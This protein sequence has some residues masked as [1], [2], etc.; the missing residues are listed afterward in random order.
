M[1][2]D[3][4]LEQVRRLL[5]P[6][7]AQGPVP[8][9]AAVNRILSTDLIAPIDLPLEDRAALD[10][11]AFHSTDLAGKDSAGETSTGETPPGETPT[12]E[13]PAGEIPVAAKIVRLHLA[14]RSAAG[15]PYA[16]QIAAG[17]AV[18]ILT[19]GSLPAGFD[20]V[21]MQEVC[22]VADDILS[23]PLAAMTSN[24]VRRRGEDYRAGTVILPRGHRLRPTDLGIASACGLS[25]LPVY[26]PLRVA[27]FST[28]DE[29]REPGLALR[30]GQIWDANRAM[31]QALIR[32]S[33]AVV[34]DLGILPDRLEPMRDALTQAAHDHDLIVTSGGMSVGDEDHVKQIINQRGHLEMWRLTIK[35]GKPVGF[36]DID[37]CPIIALPGN[38]VAAVVTFLTL[39]RLA[40]AR[41]SGNVDSAIRCL[42]L[43]AGSA[44]RK[45]AG[46]R[47]F[48][49]AK[50]IQGENGQSAA[51][52]VPKQGAAMLS[53][54]V[55]AD[56]LIDL[57]EAATAI[58]PGETIRFLPLPQ[59][60]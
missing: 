32:E 57:D 50:L 36:G 31:L 30:P 55:E 47:E 51:I 53:S 54:L 28:G 41:L 60:L 35:P 45:H 16:G 44:I 9:S 23:F 24:H 8:V 48:L 26:A 19:G 37:D 20:S 42:R 39:G 56:G 38:P 25:V 22:T 40:I 29:L 15:H 46:R 18:R 13:T 10:G 58:L 7:A 14:G 59:G 52:P 6:V 5:S 27:L 11:Y 43:P 1:T 21:V 12:G 34:S 2:L 4:A 49:P 33:G 3:E 17:K